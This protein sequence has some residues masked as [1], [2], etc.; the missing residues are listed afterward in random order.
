MSSL[1]RDE[2][3]PYICRYIGG[4]HDQSAPRV[5]LH[6]SHR[7]LRR[8]ISVI[9][10]L[11]AILVV[12]FANQGFGQAC[13]KFDDFGTLY[14]VKFSLQYAMIALARLLG[15][16]IARLEDDEGCDCF[17]A[18]L[19]GHANHGRFLYGGMLEEHL[20]DLA[21]I[22]VE[23]AGDN[24]VFGA[25]NNVKVAF[26]VHFAD[27]AGAHPAIGEDGVGLIRRGSSSPA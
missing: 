22:D 8:G 21:W 11:P 17:A 7:E 13:T 26:C 10:V 16:C 15:G 12:N 1:W 20:F 24:H 3:R 19:I 25:I 14:G 5:L 2:L 23:A 4:G 6:C 18:I 27:V 9:F